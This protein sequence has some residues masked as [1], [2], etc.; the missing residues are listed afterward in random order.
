MSPPTTPSLQLLSLNVNGLRGKQKRAAL[1]ATLQ[2]GPW[3]VVALQE[4]HHANR[5]R[6]RNGVGRGRAQPPPGMAPPFGLP[7]RQ[8]VEVWPLLF[9]P[10]PLLSGPILAAIDPNGRFVAIKCDLS[11]NQI[12]IA[13]VY[14]PAERQER[15]PFFQGSL[16]PAL[17]AGTPLALGGD[18]NCVANDQDSLGVSQAPVRLA[19]S[20]ACCLCS[21]LWG[22]R[23][24]S[25]TCIPQQGSSLTQPP[26]ARHQP[27]STDGLSLTACF[28]MSTQ[29]QFQTSSPLTIMGSLYQSLLLLHPHVAQAF[30][31]CHPASSH[32]LP[33][34]SS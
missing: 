22:C 10:N 19:F 18:W 1:F 24:H 12:T 16:L 30:G 14:A 15:T 13:S 5:Q 20:M 17:P 7:A 27:E 3:Q 28:R 8:Q 9:K 31:Q 4:T 34:R 32:T 21:K 26:Q 11:G 25:G 29:L 2:S 23:M 33:S 6:L